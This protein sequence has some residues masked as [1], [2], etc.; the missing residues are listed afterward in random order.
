MPAKQGGSRPCCHGGT[1][2]GERRPDVAR[3]RGRESRASAR[4][5][6]GGPW[7]GKSRRNLRGRKPQARR[8]GNCA[9]P[10]K[11]RVRESS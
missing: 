9:R 7:D 10:P 4:R 8:G 6:K 11:R 3:K 1:G 5:E 2:M